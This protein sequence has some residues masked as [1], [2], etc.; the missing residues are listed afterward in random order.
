MNDLMRSEWRRFGRLA[1]AVAICHGLALVL[2]SRLDAVAQLGY[3]DHAAMLIAYMLLGLVLAQVQVGSY[4]QPSRW[5]W[6][7]HRPLSPTRIFGALA[8]SALGLLSVAVFAPLLLFLVA[9]DVL[10]TQVIESRHYAALV[11]AL[12]FSAMAWLAGAHAI[13][14]R[15]KIAVAVLLAPILF[16]L[17]LASVWSLLLPVA[18]CVAWLVLIARHSFRANRDA[19][20]VKHR[21]LLLTALPLQ[22]GFF[23]LTFQLSTAALALVDLMSRGPGRTVLATDA[24]VDVEAAMRS[25]SQ[26]AFASGLQRSHDPRAAGWR[27]QLPMLR[28]VG[29][30]PDITRF[31]VR[32]QLGNVSRPWFDDKRNT[33]WT[34]SHDRMQFF[35]RDT[36]TGA[37]RGWW[38][39]RGFATADRFVDV[40][41]FTLTRTTWFAVDEDSQQQSAL[42]QLPPGEWFTAQ[43]VKTLDHVILQTNKRLLA[44]RADAA[45]TSPLTPPI[46]A[47]QVQ[48]VEGQPTPT[49]VDI[50]ELLDGWLVS[51]LYADTREFGSYESLTDPWQQVSY[52]SASGTATVVGERHGIHDEHVSV[53]GW[54]MVPVASWWVSPPL[55]ALAHVPDFLDSGLTQPPR[56]ELLPRV[57]LFYVLALTLMVGSLVGA[58]GWLRGASVSRSRRNLWLVTCGLLGLPALLSMMCLEPRTAPLFVVPRLR[59]PRRQRTQAAA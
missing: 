5:L 59:L 34:F 7:I 49:S 10:T 53:A 19:P 2:M 22:I 48:H 11:Y 20:I 25:V 31:P 41:T 24:T 8:L 52:V 17:H 50:A 58:Y 30:Q 14:S 27:E 13:T 39:A 54:V 21:V 57:P 38:G 56:F 47:W 9:T 6:L 36:F 44:Y 42:V 43:P 33:T 37:A 26:N 12:S 40:P 1:V 29:L 55:Y 51:L 4:R 28:T 35:G 18:G 15:R 32:Y 46:L 16:A 3:Q 23:L 45:A